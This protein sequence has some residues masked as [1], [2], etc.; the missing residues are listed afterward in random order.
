MK[1]TSCTVSKTIL[2]SIRVNNALEIHSIPEDLYT[3][4]DDVVI[5]LGERLDVPIRHED[6]DIS[7]KLYNRKNQSK[8]IIVKFISHKKKAQLYRKRTKLKDV[9]ISDIFPDCSVADVVQS[10]RIIL[11]EN[12]TQ[13]RK[14]IMQ[15]ANKMR[16]DGLIQSAWSLDGKLYVKTSPSGTPTRIYCEEDLNYL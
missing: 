1:L 6:I 9:K 8:S 11:N 16:R 14:R 12:L 7:H 2:N 15:N 5:K 10:M 4:T 13:Y 3:A